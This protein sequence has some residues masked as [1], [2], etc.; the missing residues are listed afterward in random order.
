[1]KKAKI[2]LGSTIYLVASHLHFGIEMGKCIDID[3]DFKPLICSTH[4]ID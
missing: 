1:M 3:A 4:N 2:I